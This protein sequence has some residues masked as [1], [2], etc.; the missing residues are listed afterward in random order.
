MATLL[1]AV[2]MPGAI[3]GAGA[4]AA[5]ATKQILPEQ[6]AAAGALERLIAVGR[7]RASAG[8]PAPGAAS[9]AALMG[10]LD[11]VGAWGEAETG[12]SRA[13]FAV[14]AQ[15]VGGKKML[16]A[17]VA[18]LREMEFRGVVDDEWEPVEARRR[19]R[20]RE[21]KRA[22]RDA[23]ARG[24]EP[25]ALNGDGCDIAAE[26]ED[27]S[28]LPTLTPTPTPVAPS[29]G[30][31]D[32]TARIAR[33]KAD[34]LEKRRLALAARSASGAV[35]PAPVPAPE[36]APVTSKVSADAGDEVDMYDIMEAAAAAE[37]AEDDH[38]VEMELL[39]EMD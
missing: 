17:R 5:S 30:E 28:A 37:A 20:K 36:T 24:D 22:A 29:I 34:A 35:A 23:K 15:A 19:R 11:R 27:P 33:N 18:E 3:A 39:A 13:A 21:A 16:R 2:T 25:P 38:D 31:E 32:V 7:R 26:G 4:R 9:T 14:H 12:L 8:T 6:L 1:P 10:L